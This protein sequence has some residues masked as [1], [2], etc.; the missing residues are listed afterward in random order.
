MTFRINNS[1]DST[2]P[3]L[4][5]IPLTDQNFPLVTEDEVIY[6]QEDN[7]EYACFCIN[8][9][10]S[11]KIKFS[12]QTN[13]KGIF[14]LDNSNFK[15]ITFLSPNST[16]DF[17]CDDF[18]VYCNDGSSESFSPTLSWMKFAANALFSTPPP[19]IAH[20]LATLALCMYQSLVNN[21]SLLDLAVVNEAANRYFFTVYPLID[22]S[23]IYNSY[24]KL[25]N[26]SLVYPSVVNVITVM[27]YDPA[28]YENPNFT[29]PFPP[30]KYIWYGNN[31]LYP[32][33]GDHAPYFS[34]YNVY[35]P[36]F[37][38]MDIDAQLMIQMTKDRTSAQEEIATY[39][40]D[41]PPANMT[42]ILITLLALQSLSELEY[43]QLLSLTSMSLLDAGIY[44]WKV[45]YT[46]WGAR[47]NQFIPNFKSY[48]QTP[49]FPGFISG[50][51]TFS[52]AMAQMLT[53]I[54]P[55]IG[56]SFTY[57]GNLSGYS[58]LVGGIHFNSDN[59]E[60]LKAGKAVADSI[61]SNYSSQI[62]NKQNFV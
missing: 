43:S 44:A 20:R 24:P 6:K 33:W 45:K 59:V 42:K 14:I 1:T 16:Y 56:D 31:P 35:P 40:A 18:T 2:S 62:I 38:N 61:Y 3:L 23:S 53:Y 12:I 55:K 13:S 47:P 22:T 21:P 26:P 57:L 32:H 11:N 4:K 46:L 19:K 54:N 9:S 48:I 8:D 15:G 5:I 37:G 36:N 34:T 27:T 52:S 39:F 28:I 58:R 25:S 51:S 50:H 30:S 41:N 29:I 7:G 17:F 60:G 10:I 49:N